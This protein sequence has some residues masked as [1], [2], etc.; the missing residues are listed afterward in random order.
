MERFA[1]EYVILR[2]KTHIN[3]K[4]KNKKNM[5]SNFKKPHLVQIRVI[6]FY[7]FVSIEIHNS[8]KKKINIFDFCFNL[9]RSIRKPKTKQ[10]EILL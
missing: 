9:L 1:N 2:G 7:R 8:N 6:C 4:K 10:K 5:Q 3:Q